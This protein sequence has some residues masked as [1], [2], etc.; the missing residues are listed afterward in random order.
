[1]IVFN[2]NGSIV[3]QYK[4]YYQYDEIPITNEKVYQD[5]KDSLTDIDFSLANLSD[6]VIIKASVNFLVEVQTF[7]TDPFVTGV[8]LFSQATATT[9]TERKT[10]AMSS[11]FTTLLTESTTA[12]ITTE[13]T[14]E[15]IPTTL[16]SEITTESDISTFTTEDT[17]EDTQS[18]LITE[19]PTEDTTYSHSTEAR[20]ETSQSFTETV[21]DQTSTALNKR[22][23]STPIDTTEYQTESKTMVT[24]EYPTTSAPTYTTER[25]AQTTTMNKTEISIPIT[26]LTDFE[27]SE[28]L[29]T[30]STTFLVT[31]TSA[32]YSAGE[33]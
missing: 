18:S 28:S 25:F 10:T 12:A 1:M 21:T 5:L 27:T 6:F 4:L 13:Y 7:Q 17:T 20:I 9:V 32:E 16:G 15:S 11:N 31:S 19:V 26:T 3:A 30:T 23:D 22:E 29:E 33:I 14:T 2:R 24:S 8:P